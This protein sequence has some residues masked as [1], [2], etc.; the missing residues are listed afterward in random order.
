MADAYLKRGDP[1]VN[2][3]YIDN[4]SSSC[5]SLVRQ[6]RRQH[7]LRE[8]NLLEHNFR[9]PRDLEQPHRHV[10]LFSRVAWQGDVALLGHPQDVTSREQLGVA[11]LLFES[12]SSSHKLG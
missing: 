4:L 2:E 6:M 12:C 7:V 11:L 5:D 3:R 10:S 1:G 9:S 8:Q